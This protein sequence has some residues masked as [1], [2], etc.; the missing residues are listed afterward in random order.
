MRKLFYL[1]FC[2][3]LMAGVGCAI[4][5]YQI[6]TDNDQAFA[7]GEANFTVNTNGKANIRSFQITLIYAGLGRTDEAVNF[8]DQ[9]SNGDRTLNTYDNHSV[10]GGPG[11]TFKDDLYCNPDWTGC[12]GWTSTDPPGGYDRS[13]AGFPAF[14]GGSNPHCQA[15]YAVAF[16]FGT[17]RQRRGYYND[18]ECGRGAASDLA[19]RIAIMNMG[20]LGSL[21]GEQG[22]WYDVNTQNAS[23]TVNNVLIPLAQTNVFLNPKQRLGAVFMDN[24]LH[25]VSMNAVA[26]V[27]P[28]GEVAT[29]S[30]TYNGFT[31]TKQLVP[32]R[33]FAV[34]ANERY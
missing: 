9:K 19:S 1:A 10:F 7:D 5:D 21:Q 18:G 34:R 25:A 13:G 20:Q 29:F 28:P 22:L 27:A 16:L 8:V 24:P 30:I 32:I 3:V 15:Y 14:D 6:I 23:Y 31:L 33:S 17:T 2:V 11:P 12:A 26:G 4:T